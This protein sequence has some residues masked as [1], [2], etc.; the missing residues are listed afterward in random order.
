MKKK[1]LIIVE[2]LPVPFDTRVWKEACTLQKAGYQVSV[3]CPRSKR[4]P[5][6]HEVLDWVYIY[7]H[8]MPEEKNSAAGYIWEYSCALFWEFVLAFWV[9]MR[10]GFHVIQGC[11]PPD[12]IFLIALVFKLFR[13][14][15]IFD[16]HDLCPEM[17]A[18]KFERS[19][20]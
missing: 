13:V 15:Y 16:H 7:R 3:I 8:P 20:G 9:F 5:K 17:F 14:R 12:T 1:V 4:H 18:V 11:N 2:N 6:F 10:R 19:K